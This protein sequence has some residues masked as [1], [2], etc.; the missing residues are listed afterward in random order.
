[1]GSL[2]LRVE[3]LCAATEALLGAD[4]GVLALMNSHGDHNAEAATS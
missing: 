3:D 1:M 4:I 2:V